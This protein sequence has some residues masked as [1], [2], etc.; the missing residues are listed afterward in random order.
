MSDPFELLGVEPS[1]ELD[2]AELERRHQLRSLEL[3]PDRLVGRP[4]SERREL[5]SLAMSVNEAYRTLK[6]P[7]TRATALAQRL[8]HGIREG[9]EPPA[10]P[11]LLM[12]MMEYREELREAGDRSDLARVEELAAEV[13]ELERT[14][15]TELS[16]VFETL[17]TGPGETSN[18]GSSGVAIHQRIAALRYYQRFFDEVRVL[19][20]DLEI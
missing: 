12:R 8:G 16:E 13:Q 7:V 1:F 14:A 17:S 10:D 18:V 4:R 2:L 3:H 20:D 6:N 11:R 9:A 15:R 5:L 19:R